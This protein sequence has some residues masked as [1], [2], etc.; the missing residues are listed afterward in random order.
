MLSRCAPSN[1]R[2]SQGFPNF[3][4][5]TDFREL[6]RQKYQNQTLAYTATPTATCRGTASGTS[7]STSTST[8][9]DGNPYSGLFP[10]TVQPR[11]L[12]L[13]REPKP[14][15]LTKFRATTS[16]FDILPSIKTHQNSAGTFLRVAAIEDLAASFA[17]RIGDSSPIWV[18]LL[19]PLTDICDSRQLIG[20]AKVILCCHKGKTLLKSFSLLKSFRI[21]FHTVLCNHQERIYGP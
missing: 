14:S 18:K 7:T 1:E 9:Q 21:Q 16:F 10:S 8:F 4:L 13:Q 20:I 2:F 19:T 15:T 6:Q 5:H 11:M 12:A 3:T 17:G